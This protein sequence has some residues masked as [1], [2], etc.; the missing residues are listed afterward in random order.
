MNFEFNKE[1]EEKFNNILK[2]YPSKNSL[3]LHALWMI[4]YH[5]GWIS[6]DALQ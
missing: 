5:E 1:N 6:Q 4:Q 3:T 2:R